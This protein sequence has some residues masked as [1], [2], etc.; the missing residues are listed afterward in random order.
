MVKN[1][2]LT[3]IAC[4]FSLNSYSETL[5]RVDISEQRL[6]LIKNQQILVSY[7][8]S[9]SSYGEGQT[10][11]SYKT[12]LGMHKIKEMIGSNAPKDTIFISR[13]NTKRT[14][15]IIKL[16]NDT[17]DDFVTSRIMWL[18]G[19]EDGFNKGK[20]IDSYDRYIYIHGTQE[21]GLIGSKASHG[22]IRMFNNDVIELYKMVK[23]GT[24]VLIVV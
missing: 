19:Q 16:P 2:A 8:I 1:T 5:I 24:K 14:A 4:F 13:I 9:S 10:E 22:C 18:E 12:P 23:E 21:E 11:N 7:P 17:K 20:G 6:Y 15:K 3:L